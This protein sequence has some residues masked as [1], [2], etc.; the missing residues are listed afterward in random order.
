VQLGSPRVQRSFHDGGIGIGI[1][2]EARSAVIRH[3]QRLGVRGFVKILPYR[4]IQAGNHIT[5]Q[6][7][8]LIERAGHCLT[9]LYIS[10]P[11]TLVVGTVRVKGGVGRIGKDCHV[12][13]LQRRIQRDL[14]IHRLFA[15]FEVLRPHRAVFH[16]DSS[17]V[18]EDLLRRFFAGGRRDRHGVAVLVNQLL[19]VTII[20]EEVRLYGLPLLQIAGVQGEGHRIF[21][22]T[23][24]VHPPQLGAAVIVLRNGQAGGYEQ[25]AAHKFLRARYLYRGL[26][27][28]CSV[29]ALQQGNGCLLSGRLGRTN[30]HRIRLGNHSAAA[31]H[32]RHQLPARHHGSFCRRQNIGL[33]LGA[34]MGCHPCAVGRFKF[35]CVSIIAAEDQH[36][37]GRNLAAQLHGHAGI[38]RLGRSLNGCRGDGLLRGAGNRNRVVRLPQ[39]IVVAPG[40]EQIR[41]AVPVGHGADTPAR[42]QGLRQRDFLVCDG[43]GGFPQLN[44]SDGA[45]V[46]NLE[47]VSRR[48]HAD[49]VVDVDLSSRRRVKNP[50]VAGHGDVQRGGS[51]LQSLF[52]NGNVRVGVGLEALAVL[53][54]HFQRLRLYI[55][56]VGAA[57]G[58]LAR[59]GVDAGNNLV[60][61]LQRNIGVKRACHCS[62]GDLSLPQDKAGS[63]VIRVK[64]RRA[65]VGVHRHIAAFHRVV[66]PHLNIYGIC[67]L[68]KWF[69]AGFPVLQQHRRSVGNDLRP[70][71]FPGS[72]LRV[73]RCRFGLAVCR[74]CRRNRKC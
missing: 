64:P 39:L 49:G 68:L 6:G 12:A 33:C 13:L 73:H 1:V 38:P 2:P 62:G 36:R 8:F 60:A 55:G 44:Q 48:V 11:Q 65:D 15:L 50:L 26:G 52:V 17:G 14:Y 57:L 10:C 63:A 71:L 28:G 20:F 58:V 61:H 53:I 37:A 47:F 31:Q 70:C 51:R 9:V 56:I 35:R 74:Q 27:G 54:H 29:A 7:Q 21:T 4:H 19:C 59:R 30:D 41:A 25:A 69:G 42:L 24:E 16:Q 43:F 72:R 34:G 5:I 22:R 23:G 67:I 66:Q 45:A 40:N 18:L 46:L 3:L 32:Q